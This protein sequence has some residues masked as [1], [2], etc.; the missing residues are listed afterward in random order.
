MALQKSVNIQKMNAEHCISISLWVCDLVLYTAFILYES[1]TDLWRYNQNNPFPESMVISLLNWIEIEIHILFPFH[2]LSVSFHSSQTAVE[3]PAPPEQIT[4]IPMSDTKIA[5]KSGYGK[6]LGVDDKKRV[7]GRSDAM[8][9]RE[10][11]EP[12]FQDVNIII[13]FLKPHCSTYSYL[14]P[15]YSKQCLIVACWS[16]M[17][18]FLLC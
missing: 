1:C 13:A 2:W 14:R 11:F 6:F 16:P 15:L 9:P 4:A 7:V 18:P 12:V 5:F 10:L 17:I 8:G 3:G